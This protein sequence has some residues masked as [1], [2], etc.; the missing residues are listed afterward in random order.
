MKAYPS[1]HEE[2]VDGVD[3][4]VICVDDVLHPQR[5]D[6]ADDGYFHK[7]Q[8]LKKREY[9]RDTEANTGADE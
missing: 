9:Q 6:V 2:A 8:R 5:R 1:R 4:I 3:V 7:G